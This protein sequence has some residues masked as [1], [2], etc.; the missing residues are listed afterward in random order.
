MEKRVES[1]GWLG[2]KYPSRKDLAPKERK[3]VTKQMNPRW[4]EKL[5]N[6]GQGARTANRHR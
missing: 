1:A 2:V 5:L 3:K 6:M 4:R